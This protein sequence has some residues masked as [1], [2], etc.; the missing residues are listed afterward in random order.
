MKKLILLTAITAAFLSSCKSSQIATTTDDVYANPVEEKKAA[1]LAAAEKAKNDAIEQQKVLDAQAAQKAKD[2]ANPYYKDPAYNKDDYYDYQY[3][4]RVNR[5]QNP[6]A[7]ASYYDPY[8]TNL[9]TYNQNPANYGTS[10]YSTY[11]YGM[12][13]NQFGNLSMGISSGY[14]YNNCFSCMGSNYGYNN[15]GSSFGMGYGYGNYYNDPFYNGYGYGSMG[16]YGGY[17]YNNYGYN[18]FN[19]GYNMGYYNGY[20]N[21]QWGYYN[22]YDP[23]SAYGQVQN[24]PRGSNGGGNGGTRTTAGMEAGGSGRNSYIQSVA[25]QQNTMPRFTNSAA[26]SDGRN[27]VNSG[28]NGTPSNNGSSGYQNNGRMTNQ[29]NQSQ[30][31]NNQNNSGYR[32]SDNNTNNQRYQENNNSQNRGNNGG[33][34]SGGGGGGGRSSGGGGNSRPR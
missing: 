10:I 19:T 14:G 2:D 22:S 5:F 13:S 28:Y 12:P 4:S 26:R 9:Y 24:S 23:N 34:N 20:N 3:A 8:Y 17:G 27:T 7:G 18:G 1:E 6:V 16:Y 25:D 33:W 31:D 11:N 32:Q 15:Y 21:A 30:S 29:R